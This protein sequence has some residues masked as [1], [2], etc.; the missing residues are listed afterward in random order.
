[1]TSARRLA[2]GAVLVWA[3]AL[4]LAQSGNE[5]HAADA[6]S[7]LGD[8][9]CAACHENLLG[10]YNQTLHAKLFTA[11]N[12]RTE[13]MRQGCEGCH[14]PAGAHV[15]AGGGSFEGI[16]T[17]RLDDSEPIAEQNAVCLECHEGG[18]RV[19][20]QGSAH[21]SADVACGTC[22]HVMQDK[23]R[24][25]MLS[26]ERE[27]DACA[28]CHLMQ[29]SELYR[30]AHMPVR[31]QKMSCSSCHNPHGT[32]ADHLISDHT[33]N[34]NCYRCHAEKRG[35]FLWEHPPAYEDCTNCHVP[36]GSTRESMLK[37]SMPRL[38]QQCHRAHGP[39][40]RDPDSPFVVGTSCIQCHSAVH[41]SNHPSG[42]K[43]TR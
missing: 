9:V 7:Y 18:K 15:V 37:L 26:A 27:I 35:P 32:V 39:S 17:F 21:E 11:A 33:V 31:E 10:H 43:L 19:Y 24:G 1:M 2:A 4:L 41:G 34:D 42:N 23:S 5:V 30:S 22:H 28:Q 20:W 40:A 25:G 8:A 14:G 12:G 3:L 16:T 13:R 38:C 6:P 29:R 36:H